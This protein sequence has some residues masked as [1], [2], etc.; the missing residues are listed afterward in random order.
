MGAVRPP[1][2]P[3]EGRTALIPDIL[4]AP[5]VMSDAFVRSGAGDVGE[6]TISV[7]GL[8]TTSFSLNAGSSDIFVSIVLADFVEFC[9]ARFPKVG[10]RLP[11]LVFFTSIGRAMTLRATMELLFMVDTFPPCARGDDLAGVTVELEPGVPI[12]FTLTMLACA[13]MTG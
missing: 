10:T 2:G 3:S 9:L 6:S 1:K 8:S 4:V 11:E 7:T 12:C 5:K 13:R